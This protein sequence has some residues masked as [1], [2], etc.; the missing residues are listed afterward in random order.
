MKELI[1]HIDR[2]YRTVPTRGGRAIQG[3]SMG[4]FGALRL[5]LKFPES[6]SSVVAYAGA[7][8]PIESIRMGL[9]EIHQKIFG[10]EDKRFLDNHTFTLA[11]QNADRIR[12]KLPIRLY[13]GTKDPSIGP[14]R[15]MHE[16]FEEVI[17]PHEVIE[18][19]DVEHNLTQLSDRVKADA[20]LF[21]A[22]Y[23]SNPKPQAL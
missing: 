10:G 7:Y 22:K 17:I 16:V 15:K 14:S 18:F 9:P 19:P 20:F 1:P 2:T 5:A 3:M 13:C 23:F 6:F 4:G 12:G 11:R 8:F 21:A